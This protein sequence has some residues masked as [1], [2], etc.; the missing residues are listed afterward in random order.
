MIS[1]APFCKFWNAPTEETLER[2][3]HLMYARRVAFVRVKE[4]FFAT[5][6]FRKI[7]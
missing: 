7:I 6:A 4:F 3:T 1:S 5:N 2:S